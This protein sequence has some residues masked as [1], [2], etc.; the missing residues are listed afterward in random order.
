MQMTPEQADHMK[1][2]FQNINAIG[3]LLFLV[4]GFSLGSVF[5]IWRFQ[6][7]INK[8]V[9]PTLNEADGVR[10]KYM[11]LCQVKLDELNKDIG[12]LEVEKRVMEAEQKIMEENLAR[13]QKMR[14]QQEA[15]Q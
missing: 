8:F 14:Q 4:I 11:A 6:H 3:Q 10:V 5:H 9:L 15:T 13:I 7:Y 12:K 2:F 1:L